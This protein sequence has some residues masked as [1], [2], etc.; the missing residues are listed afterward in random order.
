M[1]IEA[2]SRVQRRGRICHEEAQEDAKKE[3]SK[4]L[5]RVAGNGNAEKN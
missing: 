5:L 4:K 1:A 3:K 2:V